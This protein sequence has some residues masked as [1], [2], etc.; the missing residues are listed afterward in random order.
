M[1][2]ATPKTTMSAHIDV[3]RRF[4]AAINRGDVAAAMRDFDP[5]IVRVEPAGFPTSGTYRGVA[6]VQEQFANARSTWAE[7]ACEPEEL[8]EKGDK[9]VADVHVRVRLKG[10]TEWID[11]RIADGFVFRAGKVVEFRTFATRDDAR[12][13]AGL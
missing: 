1:S 2:R 10:A 6:A 8:L 9:V 13:W 12:R 3:L 4:Y 7:G 5:D 11:A